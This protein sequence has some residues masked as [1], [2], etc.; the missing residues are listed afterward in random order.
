MDT[1]ID[2]DMGDRSVYIYGPSSLERS[3]NQQV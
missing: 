3:A 1:Y 2:V